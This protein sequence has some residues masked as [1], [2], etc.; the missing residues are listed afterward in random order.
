[1]QTIWQSKKL[2]D[3]KGEGVGGPKRDFFFM[4]LRIDI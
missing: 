3:K 4:P 1:M 2:L